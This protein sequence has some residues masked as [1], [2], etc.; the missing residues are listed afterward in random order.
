M[1]FKSFMCMVIIM[2]SL[3]A[4]SKANDNIVSDITQE[5]GAK[6]NVTNEIANNEKPNITCQDFSESIP[7]SM[8]YAIAEL[9]DNEYECLD[10][11]FKWLQSYFNE[12]TMK[13]ASTSDLTISFVDWVRENYVNLSDEEEQILAKEQNTLQELCLII[14][15]RIQNNEISLIQSNTEIAGTNE[16]PID[17][18]NTNSND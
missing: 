3:S 17:I 12:I 8:Y 2:M 18:P 6:E 14:Q 7:L 13:E 4:C 10:Q 16:N 15:L 5:V 1:H 9:S 11:E